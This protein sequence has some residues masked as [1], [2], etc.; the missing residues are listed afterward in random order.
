M[1][2]FEFKYNTVQDNIV[3]E[4]CIY[5]IYCIFKSITVSNPRYVFTFNIP[6]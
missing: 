6:A 1:V 4:A 2:H 5:I 3:T